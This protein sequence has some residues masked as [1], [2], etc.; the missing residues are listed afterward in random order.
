VL[1]KPLKV[2]ALMVFVERYCGPGTVTWSPPS[3]PQRPK[4]NGGSRKR[5]PGPSTG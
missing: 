3:S 5:R 2:D 4:R 1:G